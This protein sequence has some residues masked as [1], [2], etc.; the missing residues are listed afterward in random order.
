MTFEERQEQLDEVLARYAPAPEPVAHKARQP[1][2]V[3]LD[4]QE[5]LDRALGC[6]Q[7]RRVRPPLERRHAAGYPSRSE[8]DLAL[9]NMLAFWT[10]RDAGRIDRLFRALRSLCARS[11]SGTTT[12]KRT[13]DKP[14]SPRRPTSTRPRSERTR[15]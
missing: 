15:A 14:R 10:G 5:L 3:D 11:G 13:I 9:C 2:P 4:D 7:R 6:P 8:A 1:Q 12:A